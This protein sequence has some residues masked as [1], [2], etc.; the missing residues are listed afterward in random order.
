MD[1]EFNLPSI[2]PSII[3]SKSVSLLRA[4][5]FFGNE[6]LLLLK[7]NESPDSRIDPERSELSSFDS[8]FVG[9]SCS[10]IIDFSFSFYFS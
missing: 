1:T 8:N 4:V 9:F 5:I 7:F 10:D 6:P 2:F 3:L